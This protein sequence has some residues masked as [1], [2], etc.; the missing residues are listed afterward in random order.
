MLKSIESGNTEQINKIVEQKLRGIL[1]SDLSRF[2]KKDYQ[3][4]LVNQSA[5]IYFK[6]LNFYEL[7]NINLNREANKDLS[8]HK[9]QYN[10]HRISISNENTNSDLKSA[11]DIIKE[12]EVFNKSEY[13]QMAEQRFKED[14]NIQ[15]NVQYARNKVGVNASDKEIE[16]IA[17]IIENLNSNNDDAYIKH[18]KEEF[19]DY[20]YEK[21]KYLK[22]KSEGDLYQYFTEKF[23][24]SYR[25]LFDK[26][27]SSFKR[28]TKS[29]KS[30]FKNIFGRRNNKLSKGKTLYVFDVE[31]LSEMR[32]EII[33][34][35][36]INVLESEYN[37]SNAIRKN[38]IAIKENN[39]NYDTSVYSFKLP[40]YKWNM[41]NKNYIQSHIIRFEYEKKNFSLNF[42]NNLYKNMTITDIDLALKGNNH[43]NSI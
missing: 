33:D 22:E 2:S 30:S 13:R 23:P 15:F 38:M 31:V 25:K 20:F 17:N 36:S 37:Y 11:Y 27:E 26:K 5:P 28:F 9:L 21:Q 41:K 8:E 12:R 1:Y 14:L 4:N 7:E 19:S 6:F 3:I 10:K 43:F 32:I 16:Y 29:L 34:K 42:F 35:D 18:L 39:L 40:E 24:G